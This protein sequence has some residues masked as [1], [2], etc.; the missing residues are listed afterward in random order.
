MKSVRSLAICTVSFLVLSPLAVPSGARADEG[1]L[2]QVL[3]ALKTLESRVATLESENQHYKRDAASARAEA[4]ALKQKLGRQGEPK[5]GA[6]AVANIPEQHSPAASY[7]MA[8]KAP[9]AAVPT[10]G[11]FYA[12]AS[13]GIASQRA[14][15]DETDPFTSTSTQVQGTTTD[16]FVSSSNF[17]D[18][19]GGRGPGAMVNL[20]LGYDRMVTDRFLLGAQ[21][22]G[23]VSNMRTRLTGPDSTL[24]SSVSTFNNA[25]VINGQ[26]STSLNSGNTTDHLDNRWSMSALLRGGV[27]A[28]PKDLLYLIGGLSYARFEFADQTV[29]AFGGTVGAGWERKITPSWTLKAEYRYTR[30][31]DRTV[32]TAFN[33]SNAGVGTTTFGG[34]PSTST[35]STTELRTDKVSGL[36]WQT[37]MVGM[38]H[39]FDAD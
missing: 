30:F 8:T 23:G 22:E 37:V 33:S 31:Q 4:Q 35:G 11:G 34:G 10:W 19:L 27:L 36:D 12:G 18:G 2:Q 1:D 25:G 14:R 7:A 29:G 6:Q 26:T 16:T 28:D 3:K 32:A 9:L 38:S 24:Q 5:P 15:K 39:Y 21:I 20:Y 13:F 17:T